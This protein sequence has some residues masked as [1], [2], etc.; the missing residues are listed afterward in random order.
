MFEIARKTLLLYAG[1]GLS[2][3]VLLLCVD[4]FIKAHS[5]PFLIYGS[6]GSCA[7]PLNLK[8][9]DQIALAAISE[10]KKSTENSFVPFKAIDPSRF[11][12]EEEISCFPVYFGCNR[13]KTKLLCRRC[14]THI[15]HTCRD[16]N[17][18]CCF[19]SPNSSRSSNHKF[20]INVQALQPSTDF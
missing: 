8:S 20:Y 11:T 18:L 16:L 7:Y 9:S 12:Q 15:G 6:C 10:H 5:I 19:H 4:S 13:P 1:I 17:F 3:P 14:G 2:C